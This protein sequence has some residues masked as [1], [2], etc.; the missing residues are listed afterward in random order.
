MYIFFWFKEE[1]LELKDIQIMKADLVLGLLR[2][3]IVE[4]FCYLL[5]HKKP[6][7]ASTITGILKILIRFAR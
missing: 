1:A 4:R 3:S 2:T 7:S 6:Q 5:E